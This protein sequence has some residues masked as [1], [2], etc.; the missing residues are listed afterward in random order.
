MSLANTTTISFPVTNYTSAAPSY[1]GINVSNYKGLKFCNVT[2]PIPMSNTSYSYMTFDLTFN[3]SAKYVGVSFT[4]PNNS[5]FSVGIDLNQIF[6]PYINGKLDGYEFKLTNG[7]TK[8]IY[9]IVNGDQS[10]IANTIEV[11]C[12][13]GIK[14]SSTPNGNNTITIN[15][16][17]NTPLYGYNSGLHVYSPYDAIY[18]PVLNTGIYS[19]TDINNW[20][21]GTMVWATATFDTPAFPYYYGYGNNVYKVGAQF[22]RS[23]GTKVKYT[24]YQTAWRSLWG[25]PPVVS[26]VII[27]PA[28]YLNEPIDTTDACVN[29]IMSNVGLITNII[30]KSSLPKPTVYKY[31]M[32][33]DGTNKQNSNDSVFAQW[34]FNES[35]FYPITGQQHEMLRLVSAYIKSINVTLGANAKASGIPYVPVGPNSNV[36]LAI[37]A[38]IFLGLA[39]TIIILTSFST[40]IE[41]WFVVGGIWNQ[42]VIPLAISSSS[43]IPLLPII[44]IIL[45]IVILIVALT[46][47]IHKV[48]QENCLQFLN[49]YTT[50]PYIIINDVISRTIDMDTVH[51]GYFCDGVY[52]YTQGSGLID[53]KELSSTNALITQKPLVQNFMYSLAADNPTYVTG[54]DKLFLLPYTSGI[55]MEYGTATVYKSASIN[56][57]ISTTCQGDLLIS[58]TSNSISLPSGFVTSTVSQTDADTQAQAYLSDVTIQ[59][60]ILNYCDTLQGDDLGAIDSYFTHELRIEVTPTTCTCFYNNTDRNGL[61]IGKKIY[62]NIEGRTLVLNGYY[63][64][65]G[66]TSYRIFYQIANGIVVDIL[67]MSLSTSINVVGSTGTHNLIT[68]NLDYTSNWY[69]TSL[70]VGDII[71]EID[72][73]SSSILFDPNTLYGNST[74]VRGYVKPDYSD[75]LL[76]TDNYFSIITYEADNGWYEPLIEWISSAPFYY[77]NSPSE[78]IN[79]DID[80]ICLPSGSYN[81]ALYGFNIVGRVNGNLSPFYNTLNLT[82]NVYKLVGVNTLLAATYN[83]TTSAID[84]KTYIPYDNQISIYDNINLIEIASI[85]SPNP[86]SGITYV[87]G[88]FNGCTNPP[89]ISTTT[90]TTCYCPNGAILDASGCYIVQTTSATPPSVVNNLALFTYYQYGYGGT[91]IFNNYDSN[92]VGTVGSHLTSSWWSNTSSTTTGGVLN[93]TGVWA[94]TGATNNQTIGFSVCVTAPSTKTY[95]IGIGCDNFGSIKING[96]T[97]LTQNSTLIFNSLISQGYPVSSVGATTWQY[98]IVY[99]ITLLSGINYVEIYGNNTTGTASVGVEVYDATATDLANAA[100]YTDLGAKLL[101]STKDQVGLPVTIGTSIGYTCPS[102]YSLVTC[103]GPYYCSE[104]I[105]Y[106]CNTTTTTTITPTTTTSTTHLTTTTTTTL[107]PTTTTSTTHL[108]TTT[109][110]TLAP[111]NFNISSNCS[112]NGSIIISNFTGGGGVA[113]SGI[114][115]I[116]PYSSDLGARNGS[117][118]SPYTGYTYTNISNG[119][120]YIAVED[121]N[122]QNVGV[123][124]VVVSCV[125]TTTTSLAPTT[126][127]STTHL[128]TTTTTTLAPT[129]TTSTTIAPTTTTTTTLAPTTTTSTTHLTTTTTT[130]VAPT[131]TT[132]TTH[133]TTTTTTTI[134]PTTTTSTTVA[135]TTTTTTLAPISTS[136]TTMLGFSSTTTTTTTYQFMNT[137][138]ASNT[139][140]VPVQVAKTSGSILIPFTITNNYNS[141][142]SLYMIGE[143]CDISGFTGPNLIELTGTITGITAATYSGGVYTPGLLNTSLFSSNSLTHYTIGQAFYC[144]ISYDGGVSWVTSLALNG[145]VT[146]YISY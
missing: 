9:I 111:M 39:L 82:T 93:R 112:S 90:S 22:D 114:I 134:T 77:G 89:T 83:V 116:Q 21:S 79:I 121:S 128:T 74:I 13:V 35:K 141:I 28:S 96:I 69:I 127:T 33:Y 38:G 119:T 135:P 70:N 80:E 88:T 4:N 137:L 10:N 48:I 81:N 46:A 66:D 132:S 12:A 23:Y 57:G 84:A 117:F 131:T 100:S 139:I 63:A 64:I 5:T 130:T 138:T 50:T 34:V 87:I 15:Y 136:T 41:S 52:F 107:A 8:R 43:A 122:G 103:D 24:A 1:A 123:K 76:Y 17:C 115:S 27:G 68:N 113:G 55:P 36:A 105:Y 53:N 7:I 14:N 102:G 75:F 18:F 2:V 145:Y 60:S 124:S 29:V 58:S 92:G 73:L 19:L 67:T 85:N 44:L 3:G 16:N 146:D 98:W 101:F 94:S 143:I 125:T 129:T 91:L 110:T 104:R 47:K 6:T 56:G 120:W 109:T 26:E 37:G 40:Q 62:Y 133:L 142:Q 118:M 99:P 42:W 65:D 71:T 144:K 95:Y 86:L 32:G 78:N 31:L 126:T 140:G 45:A 72:Q 20:T 49:E 106:N 11:L 97:V 54:I 108:T 30:N 25:K 51:D 59:A 61:T